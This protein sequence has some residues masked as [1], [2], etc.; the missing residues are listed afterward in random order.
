MSQTPADDTF[1]ITSRNSFSAAFPA[2]LKALLWQT[3][4]LAATPHPAPPVGHKAPAGLPSLSPTE[5]PDASHLARAGGC[6]G[7]NRP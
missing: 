5:G 6:H 7:V 4:A 3:S 1:P 2:R